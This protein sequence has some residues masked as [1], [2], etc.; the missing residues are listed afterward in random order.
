LNPEGFIDGAL[1]MEDGTIYA[2]LDGSGVWE[3]PPAGPWRQIRAPV[4]GQFGVRLLS[5]AGGVELVYNPPTGGGVVERWTGAAWVGVQTTPSSVIT[6]AWR[7][8]ST[9]WLVTE[10]DGTYRFDTTTTHLPD[11]GYIVAVAGT[12]YILP[13]SSNRIARWHQGLFERFEAPIGGGLFTDHKGGLYMG[14]N[15]VYKFSGTQFAMREAIESASDVAVLPDGDVLMSGESTVGVR[16]PTNETWSWIGGYDIEFKQV[17]G[18]SR[19]DL[20]VTDGGELIHWTGSGWDEITPPGFTQIADLYAP[21]AGEP[22]L[23]AVGAGPRLL[24]RTA[25]TWS[26]TTPPAGTTGC[27]VRG[28]GGRGTAVYAVGACGA[29][30]FVWQYTPPGWTE[31]YR[32]APPLDAVAVATD[33]EVFAAG[34]IGGARTRG[35]TW[36]SEPAARGVSIGATTSSDVFVAG[37]PDDVVY[38]DGT[39]WSRLRVVGAITPRV[40]VTE[41][42]VYFSGISDS[43]LLR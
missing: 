28:V 2:M 36:Q 37:G 6:D 10:E 27:S 33:D 15:G 42:A 23:F 39:V 14:G 21:P 19:T 20:F 17:T 32:A 24:V 12:A 9:L 34:S 4:S 29:E 22:N 31:V 26:T 8:G 41:R 35:G 7:E 38:W 25:M 18:R 30:G 43:V 13:E 3:R 11:A 5:G 1:A 16:A 40:G